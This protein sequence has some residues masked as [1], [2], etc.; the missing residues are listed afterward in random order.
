[1]PTPSAKGE[2]CT[3]IS[4]KNIV[5]VNKQTNK[6]TKKIMDHHFSAPSE[7]FHTFDSSY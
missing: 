1:M 3:V 5:Y 4:S 6:Q 7:A 2:S